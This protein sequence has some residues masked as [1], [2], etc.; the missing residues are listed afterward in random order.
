MRPRSVE[1]DDDDNDR[2]LTFNDTALRGLSSHPNA[3][4][5][6]AR[7][8]ISTLLHYRRGCRLGRVNR[9][10]DGANRADAAFVCIARS[11]AIS[12]AVRGGGTLRLVTEHCDAPRDE[13]DLSAGEVCV[14]NAVR[15]GCLTQL[16]VERGWKGRGRMECPANGMGGGVFFVAARG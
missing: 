1:T 10:N 11:R 4:S 5:S 7:R 3:S 8:L 6:R 16:L 14:L 9:A 13:D 15:R 12:T 2:R